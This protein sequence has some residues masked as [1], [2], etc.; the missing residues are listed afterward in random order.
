MLACL[1]PGPLIWCAFVSTP[2]LFDL[3]DLLQPISD[4]QPPGEDLRE[5]DSPSSIYFSL[6][7][8]R[9]S[10][11]AAE[12]S[13]QVDGD[14]GAATQEWRTISDLAP[15]ALRERSKDLEIACWY[16]EALVRSHGIAGVRDGLR[17]IGG[18]VERFWDGLYPLE[19]EDGLETKV[20]PV[21][22]LSGEGAPGTLIAPVKLVPITAPTS[23]EPLSAYHYEQAR[24]LAA[25]ADQERRQARIDA[26]TYSME[27]LE[28]ATRETP[29]E[30]LATRLQDVEEALGVCAELGERFASLCGHR[31]PSLINLRNTLTEIQDALKALVHDCGIVLPGAEADEPAQTA[32]DQG[33]PAE[34][35]AAAAA[36]AT[37]RPA[38]VSVNVGGDVI[39]S[40]EDAFRVLSK[41]AEYFRKTE[42]HSPVSYTLDEL[43]RRGRL[44]LPE[45]LAELIPDEE[46]RRGFLM[47]A[48]VEPPPAEY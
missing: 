22:G 15:A 6:R 19:D 18:L 31:A 26:G 42:P 1:G 36:P 3:E 8:A 37:A 40:R 7:S 41:V 29:P 27:Q 9:S 45:L 4:D 20:R 2:P 17:L 11:R 13:A 33:E 28:A 25:I 24:E 47:R 32:T 21:S 35:G 48:G 23:I 16:T 5:D 34:T 43:V 30:F 44:P 12:R 14:A 38:G 39:A 10:A 46:A